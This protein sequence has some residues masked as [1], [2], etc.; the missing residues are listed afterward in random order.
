MDLVSGRRVPRS[1]TRCAATIPTCASQVERLLDSDA[2]AGD[3]GES[4]AFRFT[5][6]TGSRRREPRRRA[7]ASA[8]TRSWRSSAVEAWARSIAPATRSSIATWA[9]RSCRAATESPAISSRGS[10]GRRAP[11]PR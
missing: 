2:K 5:P 11:S 1:S 7:R 3:L 10:G 9:S 8:A 4:P 6:E